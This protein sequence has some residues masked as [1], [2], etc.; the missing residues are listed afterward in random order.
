[1]IDEL[2]ECG[3]ENESGIISLSELKLDIAGAKIKNINYALDKIRFLRKFGI[4]KETMKKLNRF[5][6]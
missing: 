1:M 5:C 2:V 3:D 6:N 4:N